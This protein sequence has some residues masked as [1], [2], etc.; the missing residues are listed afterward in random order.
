MGGGLLE[1]RDLMPLANFKQHGNHC[2]KSYP[3]QCLCIFMN[4]HMYLLL[5]SG[6]LT[7]P[8]F[9]F[10][11]TSVAQD[12]HVKLQ[13]ALCAVRT[14]RANVLPPFSWSTDP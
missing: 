8:H 9:L 14:I 13:N 2:G 7:H 11:G 12:W 6:P 10:I 4:P 3:S 5:K 1:L